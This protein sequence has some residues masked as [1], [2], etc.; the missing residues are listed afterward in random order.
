VAYLVE[1]ERLF[2][3]V[4]GLPS[5]VRVQRGISPLVRGQGFDVALR[6]G[7]SFDDDQLS[8]RGW[9]FDTDA[10]EE[11]IDSCCAHLSSDTWT[12][13]FDFRPTFELVARHVFSRL[14]GGLAQLSYVELDNR[15]VGVKTRYGS[16]M[17]QHVEEPASQYRRRSAG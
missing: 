8:E 17:A 3:A 15:T 16:T 4:Q 7:V 11:I 10:A 14:V 9:F 13:L 2:T 5:P 6:V 1:I 12:G